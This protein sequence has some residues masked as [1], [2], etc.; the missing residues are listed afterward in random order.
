MEL[1]SRSGGKEAGSF[2]LKTIH[3]GTFHTNKIGE[4]FDRRCKQNELL[5]SVDKKVWSCLRRITQKTWID[6]LFRAPG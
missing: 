4:K 2:V 3:I 1:R 6:G 5:S